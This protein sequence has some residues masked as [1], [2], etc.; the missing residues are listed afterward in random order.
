V[1]GGARHAGGRPIRVHVLQHVPFEGP[2]RI[3]EWAAA[4]G[5]ALATARLFAGDPLPDPAACDLLVVMGG[6]MGVADEDRYEW[7]RPEKRFLRAAAAGPGRVL[8]VCLGAQLLA[9]A[10]GAKVTRNPEREIGWWPVEIAAEAR[11]EGPFRAFPARL[12]VFHWHGDTFA[13]PPGARAA[14]SSEACASQA[15]VAAGGRMVGVQFH[16][17]LGPEN[18]RALV[19]SCPGDLAPGRFVQPAGAFLA[20]P[21]RFDRLRPWLDVLLD[22]LASGDAG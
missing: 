3:A 17:E 11:A 21:A 2:A 22:A 5:H 10:L 9:E 1:T 20:D 15:F 16:L 12:E 4:R 6:P 14:A 18:A 13:L 8:G 7:L 19:E